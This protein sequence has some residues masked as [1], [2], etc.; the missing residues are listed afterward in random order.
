MI[1]IKVIGKPN[2][3]CEYQLIDK[4]NQVCSWTNCD[5]FINN[6]SFIKELFNDGS[7]DY[8]EYI[9]NYADVLYNS[10]HTHITNCCQLIWL[11]K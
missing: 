10:D 6:Y 1:I 2:P 3:L 8:V 5:E 9:K 7:A 4:E 11:L